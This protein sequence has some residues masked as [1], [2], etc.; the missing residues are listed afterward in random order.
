MPSAPPLV[1]TAMASSPAARW[2]TGRQTSDGELRSG[3][4]AIDWWRRISRSSRR[5]AAAAQRWCGGGSSDGGDERGDARP[6]ASVWPREDARQVTGHGGS[7][8]GRARRWQSGGDCGST[9]SCEQAAWVGQHVR[10]GARVGTRGELGVTDLA[11]QQAEQQGRQRRRAAWAREEGKE[12]EFY[13]RA[14]AVPSHRRGLQETPAW[15]QSSGDVRW[16]R[17]PMGRGSSPAG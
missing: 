9:C 10:L 7:A 13:R 12:G 11:R 1:P 8:E 16:G 15:A 17:R 5:R 6:G 14:E 3:S 4:P 2:G